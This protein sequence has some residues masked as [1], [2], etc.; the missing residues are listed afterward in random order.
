MKANKQTNK[1]TTCSILLLL[2]NNS[3]IRSHILM[4][5]FARHDLVKKKHFQGHKHLYNSWYQVSDNLVKKKMFKDKNNK[6]IVN[7]KCL[8]VRLLF[9]KFER[10][11]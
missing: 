1:Q 3:G 4:T 9:L 11:T 6:I 5:Y 10:H 2:L 7:A 8:L